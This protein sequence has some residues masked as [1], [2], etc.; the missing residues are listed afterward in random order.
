M[1]LT[2]SKK[3]VPN[4]R[5]RRKI[6]TFALSTLLLLTEA[7]DNNQQNQFALSLPHKRYNIH[8][9]D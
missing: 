1:I 2:C 8:E 3:V 5:R 9:K 4:F 7:L 6:T